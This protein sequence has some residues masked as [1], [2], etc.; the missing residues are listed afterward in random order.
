MNY[1]RL[2]MAHSLHQVTPVGYCEYSV[3]NNPISGSTINQITPSKLQSVSSAR[4]R[5]AG[6]VQEPLARAKSAVQVHTPTAIAARL[7]IGQPNNAWQTVDADT[8]SETPDDHSNSIRHFANPG[9]SFEE[10]A[11]PSEP[12]LHTLAK[13]VAF[14]LPQFHPFEENNKWWGDGFTEWRNVARG[15]PRFKGHYQPR[16]PRDL[17]FYDLNNVDTINNDIDQEFCIMWA[18]E[19]WTRRWD[20]RE[21]DVLIAQNYANEDEKDFLVDVAKYMAHPRYMTVNGRPLFILYRASLIPDPE[22]TIPRWRKEWT[23]I[24][25]VE[26]LIFMIQSYDDRNPLEFG[27]DGAMEFP[28]HKVSKGIRRRNQEH[29]IFDPN[30]SGQIRRYADVVNKSL[31]EPAPDY[32]L[33]KTVSPS[34][35][36]DARREGT[37]VTLHGSTPEAYANWLT[38]AIKFSKENPVDKKPVVFIN[39]W[40]EWAEAAYL[41]PDV[42][43]GHAY[44]NATYR[45][46]VDQSNALAIQHHKVDLNNSADLILV[47]HDAHANGAQ[48]LLLSLAKFY[49]EHLGLNIRILLKSGGALLKEYERTAP[50]T[51]L[52]NIPDDDLTA[53]FK[54]TRCQSAVFN[55]SCT[56]DLLWAA[57]DANINCVS[58]VHE[59]PAL[60]KDFKLQAHIRAI[61]K[62]SDH[63]V[64]PSDHVQN[65]FHQ[66][67]SEISNTVSIKP[68]GLYKKISN[69]PID[70]ITTF[71]KLGLPDT[72]KIVLNVGY[73]D[74]RKGFDCF[75][76]A[77]LLG[78]KK[79]QR[80]EPL[81]QR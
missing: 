51:L 17:G 58:L 15:T 67:Q 71:N 34:W 23:K 33:I 20:G 63:V 77:A 8:A 76:S 9:P 72:A 42:H 37:G 47:G 68:Q 74:Q 48:M 7:P 64:F 32:P 54:S 44:L 6:W 46:L 26:P 28:P 25:G 62:M 61:A 22:T 13:A 78:W 38:G 69:D 4:K 57:K 12:S 19:N 59:L 3:R 73:A 52:E 56:G 5:V 70:R 43:Y 60:I 53:W 24:L 10:R 29:Q 14:Y 31:N 2:L 16:I 79:I 35:D 41:E 1:M 36:N 27:C 21:N 39:A 30:Y 49:K 18:N 45:I 75:V 80:N 65:G 50:T 66:F 11:T 40:N 81:A 55:T